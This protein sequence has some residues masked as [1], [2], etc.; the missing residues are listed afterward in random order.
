[1]IVVDDAHCH[2]EAL[3]NILRFSERFSASLYCVGISMFSDFK[4]V[5]VIVSY[6]IY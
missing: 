1:M 2:D 4:E 6:Y 3:C 5:L